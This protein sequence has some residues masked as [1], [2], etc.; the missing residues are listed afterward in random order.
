MTDT[1]AM[2]VRMPTLLVDQINA[3]KGESS[4]SDA[5]C[6]LIKYGLLHDDLQK[7]Y[8]NLV[9]ENQELKINNER[10]RGELLKAQAQLGIAQNT[11]RGL[12]SMIQ[13]KVAKCKACGNQMSL[14]DLV[15]RRCVHCGGSSFDLVDEYK[16][17]VTG[18]Q[19]LERMLT[20]VGGIYLASQIFGGND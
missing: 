2:Y 8:D 11:I 6:T 3:I 18:L 13:T 20:L 19:A 10:D 16:G 15:L 7:K 4:I 17:S 9:I 12:T 5:I 1:K 14:Q